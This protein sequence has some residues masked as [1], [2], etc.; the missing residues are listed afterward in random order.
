MGVDA[1]PII[2]FC[3]EHLT[4]LIVAAPPEIVEPMTECELC[5]ETDAVYGVVSFPFDLNYV[6]YCPG[7]MDAHASEHF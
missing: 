3:I 7:C 1:K 4:P 6:V 2:P 5:K